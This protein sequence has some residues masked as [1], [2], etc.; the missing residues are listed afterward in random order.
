MPSLPYKYIEEKISLPETTPQKL[1]EKLTYYGLETEVI[2]YK[3]N[4]YLKF[5]PF[6]NRPDLFSW[7]GIIGEI[8]ILLNCKVNL[9]NFPVISEKSEKLMEIIIATPNCR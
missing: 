6:P 3:N 9:I 2:E 5:D 1:A 8:G 4:F 7:Q